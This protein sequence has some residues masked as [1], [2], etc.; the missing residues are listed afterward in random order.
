[1]KMSFRSQI[2]VVAL[3][4]P[5]SACLSHFASAQTLTVDLSSSKAIPFD[6]DKSL[7][8]S[9]DILPARTFEK[10]FAPETIK[11][12]LSAGWGPMTYRQNTEL[13]IAAWHWNPNGTWSDTAH[14]SGYFVGSAEP[15][16]DAKDDLRMS[17][18]YPLPHRGN[19]RNG[20]ASHGYSRLTDGD[21]ATYWKSNPYL[22]SKFTGESDALHPQWI[23]IDFG[24]PQ[25]IDAIR[26][27]WADPYATKF[28]V[29]YW[30]G[31]DDPMNKPVAGLWNTFPQGEFANGKGGS[32]LLRLAQEPIHA[33]FL[34][35]V[36]TESSNTCD[37]HGSSDSRNCMGYAA[38]EV[39]AGNF[40][41]DGKFID[42]VKHIKGENQTA[43]L[44]S[45]IDPWHSEADLNANSVQ[46]G[47][48]LFFKSGYTNHLPAM[49]PVSMVYGTPEDSAAELAYLRKRG[50]A[51]SYVEMGE[52]PDG[53]YMIPEDYAALYLQW[54]TALH[55]VDPQL[56]LGG[57]V[58]EG[59]N[60]DI[61][62]W[63][64]A[65]G[66]TSWLGRFVDYL[67]VHNRLNDLTFVSFEHY[68][69][70]PCEVNWSDLYREPEWTRTVLHAWRE[71]GVPDN[72]P[73][74]NT[75]SNLSW[76]LTEPMQDVMAAL[77]LADSVGSF[78]QFGGK[79]AVYYHSPIQPEPLR[80]GCRGYSTYGNFIA[81]EELN[82]K[83]Y[84]SQYFAS[85]LVNLDWVQHGAGEHRFF[86]AS[87][88]VE[89]DAGNTLV[90][91]Y[92]VARPDGEWSLLVV[93]K[94]ATNAHS[95]RIR[96]AEES[97]KSERHFEGKI[98]VT[99]FGADQ[100]V[101][102]TEGSKSH[103]DPDGPPA[104]S[105]VDAKA[106]TEFTLPRASITVFRGRI[107]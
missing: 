61:K 38:N 27:S 82:I 17:Y 14:K 30:S 107:K 51:I 35:V 29:Q 63:P 12:S 41:N 39:S 40:A 15:P 83:Q 57:P 49:I 102:H 16:N 2:L 59:V 73:L 36:M 26:I 91:A 37:T 94:D 103:A 22:T 75:E 54:A 97:T 58:F 104:V 80:S 4:S 24:T 89:D 93:N 106:D 92:A 46:T 3:L 77:W 96:F 64:D 100:Y 11:Q 74:M 45:S 56:N 50:Y 66:K 78:L 23:V 101:W 85:R 44:V 32:P 65:N 88:E 6:P 86:P 52:E 71:D 76:E 68:P 81:D 8:T 21:A 43:T 62:V 69:I 47:F 98:S 18:G 25:P 87:S 13:T 95:T 99:T 42:L 34:R 60:D 48:D 53:Q 1:M 33:R 20:G 28:T 19:T 72:V 79:G 55:K 70:P 90:T 105:S 31:G 9:L 67:K 5:A 84:S 7:G 10:V